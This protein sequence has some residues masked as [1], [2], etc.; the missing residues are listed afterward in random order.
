V[1]GAF[2]YLADGRVVR[3]ERLAGEEEL[4]R[5]IASALA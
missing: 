2:F 3:P 1:T 4:E 5:L